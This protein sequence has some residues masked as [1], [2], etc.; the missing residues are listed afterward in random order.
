M[1]LEH[2]YISVV[3]C[4]YNRIITS[5]NIIKISLINFFAESV[6]PVMIS[7]DKVKWRI[8]S[9]AGSLYL[10]EVFWKVV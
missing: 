4:E 7:G 8:S 9:Y 3:C 6:S 1:E 10:V 2:I 5:Q